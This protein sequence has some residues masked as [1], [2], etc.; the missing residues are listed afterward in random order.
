MQPGAGWVLRISRGRA[1]GL[2][3][4]WTGRCSAADAAAIP[5]LSKGRG[6]AL[7]GHENLLQ[8]RALHRLLDDRYVREPALDALNAIA[9]DENERNVTRHQHV[10][11]RVDEF[12]SQVD[13][14]DA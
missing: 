12:S 13:V 10:R 5:A 14:D 8:V 9:R 4:G 2:A 11:D 1:G 3:S 7:R 6:L